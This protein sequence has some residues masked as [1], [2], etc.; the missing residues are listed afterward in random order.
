MFDWFKSKPLTPIVAGDVWQISDDSP[1]PR[2]NT[3]HTII[4]CKDGWVR[5]MVGK[6]SIFADQR[7]REK[8]FRRVF[9]KDE[10]APWPTSWLVP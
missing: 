10:S 9:V 8:L 7:M 2:A 1:W 4:D 6:G 5:Y 3:P